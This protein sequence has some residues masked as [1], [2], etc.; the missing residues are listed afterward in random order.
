MSS[1]AL[2]TKGK[3]WLSDPSA[4]R[5]PAQLKGVHGKPPEMM[6]TKPRN[7]RP[8]NSLIFEKIGHESNAPVSILLAKFAEQKAS[9]S[10]SRTLRQLGK[11]RRSPIP[12]PSYPEQ[13]LA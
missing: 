10:T 13:K 8:S 7:G 5:R 2:S 9:A 3:R 11:T 6:S 4:S 12:R 1:M